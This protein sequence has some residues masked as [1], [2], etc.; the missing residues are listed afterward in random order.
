MAL[1]LS[2][3]LGLGRARSGPGRTKV[4]WTGFEIR[5]CFPT[6][7]RT[8]EL[9]SSSTKASGLAKALLIRRL[10]MWQLSL[11]GQCSMRDWLVI[12]DGLLRV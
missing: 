2:Q 4:K 1:A 10:L 9:W 8:R 5:R 3:C 6:Q 11:S 7:S 12:G